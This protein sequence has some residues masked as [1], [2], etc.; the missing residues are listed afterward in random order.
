[1]PVI[2]PGDTEAIA[3][4]RARMPAGHDPRC[5]RPTAMVPS[6]W[7]RLSDTGRGRFLRAMDPGLISLDRLRYRTS[8]AQASIPRATPAQLAARGRCIPQLLWS[9][10]AVRLMPAEGFTAVP[11]RSAIAACLLLPGKPARAIHPGDGPH[12]R[13]SSVAINSILRSLTARG[14]DSVLA[15]VALL[16]SYLDDHGSPI[17]YQRRRDKITAD[18]ISTD[19][20][21]EACG[22]ASA[23]PGK[24]D[25]RHRYARRYI[26]ELLTGAD[27]TDSRSPLAFT[28]RQDKSRYLGFTDTLT[29]PL[30]AALHDHADGILASLGITEPLAWELPASCCEGLS[31]PGRD[32]AD[33]DTTPS[34]ASS[35]PAAPR[36]AKR[37]SSW[38]PPSATSASRSS[39]LPARPANGRRPP[40]PPPGRNGKTAHAPSSPVSSSTASTSGHESPSARSRP[41]PASPAPIS[42]TAP[43][44]SEPMPIDSQ[45]VRPPL[46]LRHRRR[47]RRRH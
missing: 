20:W 11:F 45:P 24:G 13:R 40:R 27:L 6:Q 29:T 8:T 36:P 34:P 22:H 16:A 14:H 43:E 26:Y 35:S 3:E 15:A 17:D 33:I 41:R 38:A 2:R 28:S 32:P 7:N 23:H 19:Q 31:L 44:T 10:W 12:A 30:R 21:R 25:R 4:I 46:L 18:T 39:R 37:R 9:G 47:T 5:P 42:R 1:M